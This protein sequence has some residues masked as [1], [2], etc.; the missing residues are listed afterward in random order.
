MSSDWARVRV[1]WNGLRSWD[2]LPAS[3][4]ATSRSAKK[5]ACDG[6]VPVSMTSSASILPPSS[7]RSYPAMAAVTAAAPP[8]A[9]SAAA[10]RARSPPPARAPT[11]ASGVDPSN[12]VRA[13]T[14]ATVTRAL[15][16]RAANASSSTS[17]THEVRTGA[18]SATS[19]RAPGFCQASSGKVTS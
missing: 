13:R 1:S 15:S 6:Q 10:A 8:R 4:R 18:G 12:G 5:R 14:S 19:Q 9:S 11:S 2:G 16:A 7:R 17:A 3:A